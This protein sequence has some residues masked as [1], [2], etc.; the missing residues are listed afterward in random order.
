M[1]SEYKTNGIIE[2]FTNK[3]IHRD[4]IQKRRSRDISKINTVTTRIR[5][6]RSERRNVQTEYAIFTQRIN[7]IQLQIN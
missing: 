6:L 2:S 3:R 5:K 7:R 1:S 4:K